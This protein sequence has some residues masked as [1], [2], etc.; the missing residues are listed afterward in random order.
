[1]ADWTTITT[2]IG[3]SS[4]TGVVAWYGTRKAAESTNRQT[5]AELERL[6]TQHHEDERRNRQGTYHDFL[7]ADERL[8]IL[9]QIEDAGDAEMEELT[10][11]FP[12]WRHLANGV[13]LFGAPA[14]AGKMKG[15]MDT[16]EALVHEMGATDRDRVAIFRAAG[17]DVRA[18]RA[19][20]LEAMREDVG[21][22]R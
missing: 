19:G 10:K 16:L 4:V 3:T 11:L 22:S 15:L 18:Q 6:R 2:A 14:V 7:T 20:L 5:E 1:M 9:L 21:P 17:P 8:W 13:R 12:R